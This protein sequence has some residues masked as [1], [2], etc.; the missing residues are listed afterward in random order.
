M[1]EEKPMS[2]SWILGVLIATAVLSGAIGSLTERFRAPEFKP[3]GWIDPQERLPAD[4]ERV[5]ALY[6]VD[7]ATISETVTYC[8]TDVSGAAPEA[9]WVRYSRDGTAQ[10][11]LGEPLKW[12][13]FPI[14]PDL[15]LKARSKAQRVGR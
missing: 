2:N 3:T 13:P 15:Y 12:E 14:L 8:I 9:A 6:A 4:R 10:P 7:G 11:D 1:K 5:T